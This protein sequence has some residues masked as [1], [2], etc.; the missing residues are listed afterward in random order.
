MI[1]KRYIKL[2]K[3]NR[4]AKNTAVQTDGQCSRRRV[5]GGRG[6]Y[7]AGRPA[8]A[9]G[10]VVWGGWYCGRWGQVCIE[11]KSKDKSKNKS[12]DKTENKSASYFEKGGMTSKLLVK[13][14]NGNKERPI[15]VRDHILRCRYRSACAGV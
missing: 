10:T 14:R 15:P 2:T 11:D 4:T 5:G 12:E 9:V 3:D 7:L 8:G 13:Y 6:I 1:D